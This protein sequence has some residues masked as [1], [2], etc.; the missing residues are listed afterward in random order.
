MFQVAG[1]GLTDAEV[2]ELKKVCAKVCGR[3]HAAATTS[4]GDK[5]KWFGS[6][7]NSPEVTEGLKTMDKYLNVQC[8]RITFARKN[9]GQIVDQ[10]AANASDYGQVLPNVM[11]TVAN[12]R[13]SAKHTSSGLR[14]FAMNEIIEAIKNNDELEK[15]NYVYHEVSHKVL[16]TVDFKYGEDDCKRLAN[17][18]PALAVR[19]ADN[20]GY[21]IGEMRP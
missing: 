13:K 5:R 4:A 17:R 16:D 10:V 8:T 12:F 2:N 11:Q 18:H 7:A 20:W 19:N 15:V 6:K 1:E 14:I 3:A 9:T 21:Y